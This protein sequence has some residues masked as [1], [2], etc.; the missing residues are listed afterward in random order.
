MA[1][2]K[3]RGLRVREAGVAV[4]GV[5]SGRNRVGAGGGEGGVDGDGRVGPV[6]IACDNFD[7]ARGACNRKNRANFGSVQKNNTPEKAQNQEREKRE[8]EGRE[9]KGKGREAHLFAWSLLRYG[10][11]AIGP[12]QG[13]TSLEPA[14]LTRLSLVALAL[15]LL[16]PPTRRALLIL[17]LLLLLARTNSLK[18]RLDPIHDPSNRRLRLRARRVRH[19]LLDHLH[20]VGARRRVARV[21]RAL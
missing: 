12:W 7:G 9:R 21:V 20:Q 10:R 14:R 1:D 4:V 2:A 5:G 3:A 8:R 16:F 11:G 13:S 18:A 17:L 6:V 15:A 19:A